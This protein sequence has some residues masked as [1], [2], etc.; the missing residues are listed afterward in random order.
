[1]ACKVIS[2]FWSINN[3]WKLSLAKFAN[4]FPFASF[5]YLVVSNYVESCITENLGT[6]VR[7]R[8]AKLKLHVEKGRRRSS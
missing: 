4:R 2:C 1:M 3:N 7:K 6:S 5:N 8:D